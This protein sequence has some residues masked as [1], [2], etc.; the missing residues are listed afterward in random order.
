MTCSKPGYCSGKVPLTSITMRQVI[1][2][3]NTFFCSHMHS[4][5]LFP[6][7]D[8]RAKAAI[9]DMSYNQLIT[10]LVEADAASQP[11]PS[12]QKSNQPP[13]PESKEPPL[14]VRLPSVVSWYTATASKTAAANAIK[15]EG[16]AAVER[17]KQ[18]EDSL[19]VVEKLKKARAIEEF[20]QD[21]ASQLTYYG[22]MQLHSVSTD[23]CVHERVFSV[24][25]PI[26]AGCSYEF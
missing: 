1:S 25:R 3:E 6:K 19:K 26:M 13:A 9:R 11:Q 14:W 23:V 24:F 17:A 15:N 10:M 5:T 21:S 8:E 2:L 20:L 16:D 7:Q 18:E 4:H 12:N 22:L